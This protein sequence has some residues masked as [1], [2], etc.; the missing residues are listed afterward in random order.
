MIY[1]D[2]YIGNNKG[3]KDQK[4]LV[5]LKN[6][7]VHTYPGS[8][9]C[10]KALAKTSSTTITQKCEL[11]AVL[12]NGDTF[13]ANTSDGKIWKE[14]SGTVSLV[15]TNTQ[16]ANFGLEYSKGYLY[17][18]AAT[19]L[20]RI[21][22]AEA[23]SEASWSSEN[24]T[25]GTFTNTNDH[26]FKMAEVRGKLLIPN[27]HYLAWVSHAGAFS[28]NVLDLQDQHSITAVYACGIWALIGTKVADD[29]NLAGIFS[30]DTLNSTWIH[31]DYINEDGV[32]MFING[33]NQIYIQIGSVGNIYRWTGTKAVLW[34]RLRDNDTIIDTALNPYGSTNLN[35]LPLVATD[36]GVFSLGRSDVDFPITQVIEYTCS[37]SSAELAA[38]ETVG[39]N[40]LLAWKESTTYG[41]DKTSSN[42]ADAVIITPEC[43]GKI[44]NVKIFY[45]STPSTSTI[46]AR[47][48]I[49]GGSWTSCAL[50]EDTEDNLVFYNDIALNAK[51]T[52]QMEIT[53]DAVT[54]NTPMID[55]IE[56][57]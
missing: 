41:L 3:K 28:A 2:W 44:N 6:C 13:W 31:E 42:Y 29:V 37:D 50:T 17:F 11:S 32:N 14:T 39:N 49:D 48:K 15:H 54:T 52:A 51:R 45:D 21:A 1:G 36:D 7:D 33:D 4:G 30:W 23:S 34:G 55:R 46:T 9:C 26:A 56:I 43:Q 38:I 19:K 57:T 5:S 18:A 16:G 47:Y 20:G 27:K 12:P 25:W 8:V 24:D 10:S 35:G 22:E 53:L 40:V